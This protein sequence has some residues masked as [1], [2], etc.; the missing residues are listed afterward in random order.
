MTNTAEKQPLAD[1]QAERELIG[2]LLILGDEKNHAKLSRV[3]G[4]IKA[5]DFYDLRNQTI[6]RSIVELFESTRAIDPRLLVTHL[7]DHD[8][9]EKS[10]GTVYI[11]ECGQAVSTA[12]HLEHYAGIVAR[13]GRNRDLHIAMVDLAN[14]VS[15]TSDDDTTTL[16]VE[17]VLQ[18]AAI[19]QTRITTVD[20]TKILTDVLSDFTDM[21]VE[22]PEKRYEAQEHLGITDLD[23][24]LNGVERGELVVIAARPSHG[25]SLI[26]LQI[27]HYWNE[28]GKSVLFISEEM[29]PEQLAK[30]TL[31][32]ATI[33]PE[34]SWH[35]C[36]QQVC[37]E[38]LDWSRGRAPCYIA[39]RCSRIDAV[40]HEVERA[41]QHFG[42]QLVIVDYLQLVRGRGEGRYEQVTQVSN[43][44]KRLA[45]EHNIV[46]IALA[47]LNREAEKEAKFMPKLHHLRD[48]GAIEQDAD[49]IVMLCWPW[50]IDKSQEVNE[51]QF[52]IRKNRNR[53]IGEVLVKS[54]IE[55]SRQRI[56]SSRHFAEFD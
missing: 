55:P 51:Y 36:S 21:A 1:L 40:A 20:R 14:V 29:T 52:F 30:R 38:V 31:Q 25:K 48:S 10:G 50:Q 22:S 35:K 41:V 46:V 47:Q 11:A 16:A 27:A 33:V 12:A 34:E 15:S 24:A 6:Y 43:E 7:R 44:L 56:V 37:G 42:V 53:G 13:H 54:T 9:L 28:M 49:V 26:A 2:S 4:M 32:T 39:E 3:F 5:S 17:K 23:L 45:H 19:A 8:R 18:A